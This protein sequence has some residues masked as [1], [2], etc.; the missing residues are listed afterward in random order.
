[1]ADEKEKTKSRTLPMT[2]SVWQKLQALAAREKR[3][4]T[5]QV[6]WMTEQRIAELDAADDARA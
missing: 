5:S 2:D 3:T 4:V 1:M 6:V